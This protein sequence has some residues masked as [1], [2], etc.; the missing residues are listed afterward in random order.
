MHPVSPAAQAAGA[1]ISAKI[2]LVN[3]VIP[4]LGMLFSAIESRDAIFGNLV[5]LLVVRSQLLEDIRRPP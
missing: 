1:I 2:A 3:F 4:G 5:N